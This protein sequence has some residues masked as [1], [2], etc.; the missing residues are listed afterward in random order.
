MLGQNRETLLIKINSQRTKL[1]F[2][3]EFIKKSLPEI[4]TPSKWETEIY[5]PIVKKRAI[6][7]RKVESDSTTI[8]NSTE[9][10]VEE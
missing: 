8:S 7:R 4:A 9:K 2:I 1:E 10:P 3:W 6:P 5:I